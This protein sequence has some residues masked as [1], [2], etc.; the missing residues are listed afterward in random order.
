MPVSC[1]VRVMPSNNR[2]EALR[3]EARTERSKLEQRKGECDRLQRDLQ[4]AKAARQEHAR[5][6]DRYDKTILLLIETAKHG[7]EGSTEKIM[8][9]VTN[10][11]RAVYGPS[12]SFVITLVEKAGRPEAEFDVV[13]PVGGESLKADPENTRGGGIV[14]VVSLG[15]RIAM[16]ET[17][18]PRLEGALILDEPAKHVSEEYVQP[19]AQFLK[20]ISGVFGRQVIMVTH[21]A[22]LAESADVAYQVVLDGDR[23][24]VTKIA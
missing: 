16:L 24:V 8:A 22:V 10:A 3:A 14:D 19:T 12:Y 23:S 6:A 13:S 1:G 2:L 20:R 15:L 7:R 5:N 21:Q 4:T 18:R 17:Y 11:L 9:T